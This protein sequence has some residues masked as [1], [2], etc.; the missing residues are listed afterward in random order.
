MVV[1][2]QRLIRLARTGASGHT[3]KTGTSPRGVPE[4]GLISAGLG[5][6]ATRLSLS[7]PRKEPI[8]VIR[9]VTNL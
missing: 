9:Q 4:E 7:G 8:Q 3:G 1:A 6:I 5:L 2:G